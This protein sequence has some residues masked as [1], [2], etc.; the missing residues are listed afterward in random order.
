MRTPDPAGDAASRG[1]RHALSAQPCPMAPPP[2]RRDTAAFRRVTSPVAQCDRRG[3]SRGERHAAADP[4]RWWPYVPP[5]VLLL[6]LPTGW[7]IQW[8]LMLADALR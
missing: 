8:L 4:V 1:A 2:L 3:C 6:L 5:F 7:P